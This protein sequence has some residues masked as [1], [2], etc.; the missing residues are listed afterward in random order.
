MSNVARAAV[1]RTLDS[2]GLVDRA[3]DLRAR[4][5]YLLDRDLRRRNRRLQE[6]N[7]DG[8]SLPPPKLVYAIL[9]HFDLNVYLESGET[10]AAA[11]RRLL[12][13][14]GLPVECF[15][16]L[17]DFGCGCGRVIRRWRDLGETHLHGCDY[18]PRLVEWCR[19]SLPFARFEING[20]A[21][22]L[23]YEDGAFDF[24]YALSVFTHLTEDLQDRW[25][26]ELRRVLAPGGVLLVTVKGRAWLDSASAEDRASFDRGEAV[27]QA[28]RYAGKNLCAAFHPDT[29]VREHLARDLELLEHRP[30]DEIGTQDM[31]LLRKPFQ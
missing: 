14:H 11:I 24:V 2:V 20:L 6:R 9:G 7:E 12:A 13:E 3:Y 19:R 23:P 16:S 21:P 5:A 22:P 1:G 17:L 18:N 26:R 10:Q 29:Y 25:L 4:A 30:A 8:A 15:R 27:F 28:E 31:V